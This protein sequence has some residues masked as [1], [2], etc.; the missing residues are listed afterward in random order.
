[1]RAPAQSTDTPTT[2]LY[3]L[4]LIPRL[5]ADSAWTEADNA[6]IRRHVAHLEAGTKD[7]KVVLAGR[8][9]EPGDRTMGL[10]I[11]RAADEARARDFMESDPAVSGGIMTASLHP[12]G[13]AFRAPSP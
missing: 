2:F 1:M 3:V 12:Y 7:G 10:V 9:L 4:R 5:H 13:I 11:F 6:L 8:T